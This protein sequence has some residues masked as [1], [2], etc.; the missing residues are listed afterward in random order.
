MSAKRR[1]CCSALGVILSLA[2]LVP[3]SEAQ[4]K[5]TDNFNRADGAVGLG[6][7]T[8]GNGVQ[9][10]GNQLATFGES[11]VA[12][13]IQRTLDVTF[14]LSF[15]FDFNT[16][17]PSDGGWQITFNAATAEGGVLAD[18]TGE[19]GVY[20][21]SGSR[22]VRTEFQTSGGPSNQCV[23]V[24]K[25]QRDY[26]AQAHISGSVNSDFS[27]TIT[28]R[29]KDGLKPATVTIETPAPA[30]AIQNPQGSVLFFGNI[31]ATYGPDF[32]DNF[33]VSLN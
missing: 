27:T 13:G 29:Y 6:W 16:D 17:A 20:Q 18:Y 15:S 21:F 7:S 28:V 26:T 12:G 11:E 9:I 10:S 19:I 23:N 31:N 22:E 5:V 4:F 33:S 2:L 8:W 30:G 1:T 3:V 24:V 14:P 32:F 25:G